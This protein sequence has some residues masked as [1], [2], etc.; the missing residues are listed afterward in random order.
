[1]IPNVDFSVLSL[2][3]EKQLK[4]WFVDINKSGRREQKNTQPHRHGLSCAYLFP[5]EPLVNL[6]VDH[7]NCPMSE[8]DEVLFP[9]LGEFTDSRFILFCFFHSSART[10]FNFFPSF[11]LNWKSIKRLTL[12]ERFLVSIGGPCWRGNTPKRTKVQSSDE[13]NVEIV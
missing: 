5:R 3:F 12:R 13:S 6:F 11:L 4:L 2:V 10:L 9:S 1:M 7:P 8:I